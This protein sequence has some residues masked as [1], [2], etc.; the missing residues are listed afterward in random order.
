MPRTFGS[1]ELSDFQRGRIFGQYEGAISQRQIA[2]N[3]N[4]P[5]STVNRVITQYKRENKKTI[6]PRSGRPGPTTR[7]LRIIKQVVEKNPR[8]KAAD[9]AEIMKVS[10]STVVKYLHKLHYYG[11]AARRKPLLTATNIAKR[12]Q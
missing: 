9:V 7:Y 6:K 1:K 3:L 5:L 8:Y 11:R 2:R 12:K 4:I 10:R